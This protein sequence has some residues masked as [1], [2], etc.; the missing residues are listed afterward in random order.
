MTKFFAGFV[1]GIIV[2]TIGFSGMAR[3]LDSGVEAVKE[4]SQDKVYDNRFERTFRRFEQQCQNLHALR[5]Q[6]RAQDLDESKNAP[7]KGGKMGK[8]KQQKEVDH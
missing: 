4:K 5:Q 1:L 3:L 2:A 7:K 8:S 6:V